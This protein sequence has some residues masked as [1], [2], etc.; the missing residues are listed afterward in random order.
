MD[1]SAASRLR[2]GAWRLDPACGE[3][4]R[5]GETV[6]LDMRA[7]RL[8]CCLA[9][10]P[11]TVVSIDDLLERVWQGVIVSPDSVYQAVA[12]LRRVLGD[13]SRR[14]EYI[15]TVPRLG[16]RLV[17]AVSPWVEEVAG[18]ADMDGHSQV[19]GSSSFP[20][21]TPL[22]SAGIAL[23]LAL[24]LMF[25]V[26]NKGLLHSQVFLSGTNSSAPQRS[27]AVLPFLD[28]TT[29]EMNEEYFADGMTEELIGRL[30]RVP[31]LRVPSPTSSFY[32]KGRKETVPV[33]A[34]ALG[35]AY[36][37][38]GSIRKSDT[39]LRIAARLVRAADGYVIWTGTYEKPATDRLKA[40]EDI[41]DEVARALGSSLH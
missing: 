4:F 33:I 37:L 13:D 25:A 32:Y 29:Q 39:T 2:I 41:A 18:A 15:E 17:A 8:L 31:G 21:R 1:C 24:I 19:T 34:K 40:Q 26:Y 9:D 23:G 11:G 3:L 36:V 5:D 20:Y 28:L 38:D 6:K 12:S 7:T 27:L 22:I 35:V 16:Y 10:R 30:S 14:P